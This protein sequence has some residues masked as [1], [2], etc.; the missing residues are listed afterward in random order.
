MK[1]NE[2][3]NSI[4]SESK[5]KGF[6]IDD[7]G[8]AVVKK[9]SYMINIWKDNNSYSYE[10]LNKSGVS[11]GNNFNLSWDELA[12]ELYTKYDIALNEYPLYDINYA[13]K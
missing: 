2:L 5:Y 1:F 11:K 7:S 13:L 12:D 10:R 4:I 9:G 8:S 6:S 3:C